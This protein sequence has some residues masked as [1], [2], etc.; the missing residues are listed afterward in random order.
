MLEAASCWC[1]V[2]VAVGLLLLLRII[3]TVDSA[4]DAMLSML[5]IHGWSAHDIYI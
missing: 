3:H 4:A 1:L 2:V 5:T